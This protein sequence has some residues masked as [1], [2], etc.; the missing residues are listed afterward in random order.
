MRFTVIYNRDAE[1]LTGHFTGTLDRQSLGD[2]VAEIT[3]M[4]SRYPCHRFLN[5]CREAVVQMSVVDIY[6]T[7]ALVVSEGFSHKWKRALLVAEEKY[8]D[9]CFFEDAANNRGVKVKV[10]TDDAQAIAWLKT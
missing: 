6:E 8:D 10:F 2:Y 3:R 4:A 1:I 7:P 9:A 5:D